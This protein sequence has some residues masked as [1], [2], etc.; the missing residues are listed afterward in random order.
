MQS[1]YLGTT[2]D[3]QLKRDFEY[4]QQ[5]SRP[6]QCSI[7]KELMTHFALG[8]RDFGVAVCHESSSRAPAYS[9]TALVRGVAAVGLVGFRRLPIQSSIRI[10]QQSSHRTA[11]T[12]LVVV[13]SASGLLLE[14]GVGLLVDS[15][16]VGG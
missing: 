16:A 9:R 11:L 15:A 4:S 5:G 2:V 8:F 12:Q 3:L 6:H 14:M 13:K 1:A 10:T 7:L